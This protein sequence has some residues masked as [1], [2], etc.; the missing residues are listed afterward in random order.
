MGIVADYVYIF[1]YDKPPVIPMQ[2]TLTFVDYWVARR[3]IGGILPCE[4]IEV[5]FIGFDK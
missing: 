1:I 5:D 3:V 2:P 4:I